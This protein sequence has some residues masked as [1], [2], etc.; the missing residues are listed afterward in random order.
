MIQ[1]NKIEVFFLLCLEFHEGIS[2]F[3]KILKVLRESSGMILKLSETC[4]Q[5]LSSES[6]PYI[7]WKKKQFW[8]V[9]DCKYFK[10]ESKQLSSL[11]EIQK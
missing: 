4:I 9:A 3:I 10:E 2:L 1:S 11:P 7:F 6:F 8:T 5:E